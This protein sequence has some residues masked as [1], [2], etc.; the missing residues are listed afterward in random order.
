VQGTTPPIAP[1]WILAAG[2]AY[3]RPLERLGVS[4]FANIDL[5]WQS[6][7]YVGASARPDN[8]DFYQNGYAVVG[9]RIGAQSMSGS[10][11]L[12]VWARNLFDQR[13][14][15]ILNNTTLQPGSI[16]G[17]VIEPRTIGVTLA[18]AW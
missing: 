9:A 14:W 17:F 3:E 1:R 4:A 5:R 13:A 8:D 10:I 12:E 6:R 16:S 11:R 15:S 7:A 18:G 2:A